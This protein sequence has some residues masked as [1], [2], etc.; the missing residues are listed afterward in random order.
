MNF[1]ADFHGFEI[2]IVGLGQMLTFKDVREKELIR[3]SVS[4]F[5]EGF[6]NKIKEEV[7]LDLFEAIRRFMSGIFVNVKNLNDLLSI[8]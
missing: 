6:S 4:Y 7:I 2:S 3:D 5:I 1:F 8:I